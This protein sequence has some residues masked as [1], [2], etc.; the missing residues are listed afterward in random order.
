[1]DKIKEIIYCHEHTT[2]DL[3]GVKKDID[4]RLDNIEETIHEFKEL[5]K[6]KV[7]SIVDVTNRGIG[8]NVE[9]V[10][11]VKE[12]IGINILQ[13]TGYYK[14]P[15][16]PQEVYDLDEKNLSKIL[17]DEIIIG[18]DGTDTKA[19]VIGEVGTSLKKI[20]DME[21]KVLGASSR[22]S[23]ETGTPIITHTTLGKLGIEQI[24]LFKDYR[25]DLTKVILSHIDLS[26]D[27][28]YMIKLA[29]TGVNIAFDTIG[30][31]NYQPD[32]KRVEWLK[33]LVN[34]GYEKQI[35]MSM[36]I[37]RRSHFKENGGLGYSYLIDTFLPM[38]YKAEINPKA[39]ENMLANN[40]KNI[41]KQL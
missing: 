36:D 7:S 9:Y 10:N 22:A 23:V 19:S 33:E 40:I 38:L 5:K 16:L 17:I 11:K 26:G 29:D 28:D 14:E 20:E 34:R 37:T 35:L 27:L 2:I 24:E 32:E 30:K 12:E 13:A 8:R 15:F 1:M 41:F 21:R 25:V 3:S 18:I 39:I 31:N 4:C 6:R